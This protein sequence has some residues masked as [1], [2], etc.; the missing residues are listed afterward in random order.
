M[1]NSITN[2]V[3]DSYN[4]EFFENQPEY[5]AAQNRVEFNPDAPYESKEMLKEEQL[6]F[7]IVPF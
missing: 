5:T 2:E 6:H 4:K 1:Q 3:V 7:S